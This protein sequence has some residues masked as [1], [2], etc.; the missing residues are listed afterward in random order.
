[1]LSLFLLSCQMTTLMT[2]GRS[3]PDLKGA[4]EAKGLAAEANIHRDENG[5][6]YIRAKSE[7]DAAF[8]LGYAH[9]QDR[10]FQM[11]LL[12][13]LAWGRMAELV[14][15][16]SLADYDVFMRS[17]DLRAKGAEA[18]AAMDPQTRFEVAAYTAGVNAG[19]EAGKVP[20]LEHRLLKHRRVQ[21]WEPADCMAVVYL[22]SWTL[23]GNPNFELFALLQRSELDKKDLDA[24]SRLHP[25]DPKTD[26]YWASLQDSTI[27]ELTL[28]F[29]RFMGI[30]GGRSEPAASNN[31]VIGPERSADGSPI[32]ANDPHLASAVPSTWYVAELKA[33]ELHA[34]GA[35]LPGFPWVVSGHNETLAWGVTNVMADY[36]DLVML[37]REGADGYW[38]EG[39][40]KTLE[41]QS[42]EVSWGE[43]GQHTGEVLLTE[44]GP[45]I[46]ELGG[47]HVV[48][49]R[50]HAL[51][52]VDRSM[53]YV[54]SL[55][56]SA[57][58]EEALA[59]ETSASIIALNMGLAD[60]EG[61]FA[62][63]AVGAV[64]ARRAH[65]GRVPYPGSSEH[66]G[67]D[68]WLDLPLPG[69]HAPERG[70]VATANNRP[71]I[72]EERA[73][74]EQVSSRYA[75]SWR[76]DR[77]EELIEAQEKHDLDSVG[78]M[79]MDDLDLHF[80]SHKEHL[81]TLTLQSADGQEAHRLLVDWNG[82]ATIADEGPTLWAEFQ[83]QILRLALEERLGSAGLHEAY[84]TIS[85]GSTPLDTQGGLEHFFEDPDSA[86]RSALLEA[87]KSLVALY[88]EET[89]AWK[90]GDVHPLIF[91]HPFGVSLMEAGEVEWGGTTQTVS[92][93]GFSW[94][95]S[96]EANW[97]ASLRIITPLSDV[98][99]AEVVHPPGQSGNVGS[100]H[101]QDLLRRWVKGRRVP[102][103]FHD[104]DVERNAVATLKLS[105]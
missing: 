55:N 95:Q 105:P 71:P 87:H 58:V 70:H 74:P 26:P 93:G 69:E 92:P 44:V 76:Y 88:G 18:I 32:L 96:Y 63:Q 50:W 86:L 25:D 57:T 84:Q 42:I 34:A 51:E 15:D 90:W 39:E 78:A 36:V 97:I 100:D 10:L 85:P 47:T 3:H 65:T 102:L 80:L 28:P 6:A 61:D 81:E 22:N 72:L 60:T 33:G 27:G 98:G 38:L 89:S 56:Y 11:D 41:K 49:L 67:W 64:P 101:Y 7:S 75:P 21:P 43:E 23:A 9:A 30:L 77:I 99:K 29:E 62:W 35:T 66:H 40:L 59:L 73:L 12:R 1:M 103:W 94:S 17:L 53:D 14:Q 45:V 68:G 31:W 54:R 83:K 20:P 46:T 48:A 13:S 24:L 16:E 4:S 19:M 5:I 8:A 37:E 82:H 104:E 2:A 91:A 52:L 79:Q